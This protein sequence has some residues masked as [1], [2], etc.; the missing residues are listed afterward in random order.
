MASL[1]SGVA[2]ST[3]IKGT[4]KASGAIVGD[5]ASTLTYVIYN[6]E[7]PTEGKTFYYATSSTS[8]YVYD[9][10]NQETA[11]TPPEISAFTSATWDPKTVP[12]PTSVALIALGLAAFCLKRKVA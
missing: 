1:G 6:T 8:G 5:I 4:G 12:E 2:D 10:S 7:A 11:I 3:S 9:A